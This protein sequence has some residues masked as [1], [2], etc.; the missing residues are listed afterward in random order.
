MDLINRVYSRFVLV[1]E[2]SQN[3]ELEKA[4]KMAYAAI[5]NSLGVIIFFTLILLQNL[6][7]IFLFDFRFQ[8]FSYPIYY[9]YIGF[10]LVILIYIQLAKKFLKPKLRLDEDFYNQDKLK[11]SK[12]FYIL[13]IIGL[14]LFGGFIFVISRLLYINYS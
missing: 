8:R 7:D 13:F 12:R 14:S 3:N 1:Y 6:I 2:I 11:S 4:K 5:R 9:I 10:A